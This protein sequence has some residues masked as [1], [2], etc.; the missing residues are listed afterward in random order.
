MLPG[1]ELTIDSTLKT[2]LRRRWLIIVPAFLGVLGGLL[3]LPIAAE[4]VPIRRRDPGRAAARPRKLRQRHGHRA[5]GGSVA[6]ARAAGAQPDAAR[7][8]DHRF[9][10]VP[11]RAPAGPDGGRDRADDEARPDRAARDA[12]NFAARR[13]VRSVPRVVRLPEPG[14]GEAGGREAGEL[15]HRHECPGARHA[16]RPDERV[17]RRATGRCPRAPRGAG[18]EAQ[19]VPRAELRT[20]ADPDADQHA[21]DPEHAARAPGQGR[22][23]RAGPRPQADA[24]APLRGRPGRPDI[25]RRAGR[26]RRAAC[27]RCAHE[28]AGGRDTAAAAGSGAGCPGAD[29]S[30]AE[31]EAPGRHA[32]EAHH[33]GSRA[34]GRGRGGPA[35]G[36]A[37]SRPG[38]GRQPRRG[39]PS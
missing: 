24:R 2:L 10:S 30:P 19:A 25:R 12:R 28:A 35:G 7:E 8:A 11:G 29:G 9:R 1:R 32:D 4:P 23:P 36:F 17:P 38:P 6:I 26:P 20:P 39:P 5:R 18:A 33:R 14:H 15:L 37:G 27:R 34:A 21:G 31:R 3:Y 22:I 16:G 13:P